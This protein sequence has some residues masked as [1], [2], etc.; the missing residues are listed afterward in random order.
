[1]SSVRT[2]ARNIPAGAVPSSTFEP[3]TTT[4]TKLSTMKVAPMVGMSVIVGANSAPQKPASA[5]P[6]PKL[7]A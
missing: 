3:P 2:A 6:M 4:V 5:A 7:S 1:L